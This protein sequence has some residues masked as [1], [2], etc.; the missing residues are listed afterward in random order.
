[1]LGPR[2]VVHGHGENRALPSGSYQRANGG[3]GRGAGKR[4]KSAFPAREEDPLVSRE[5]PPD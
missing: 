2:N 5:Q 3:R 1:M 4:G